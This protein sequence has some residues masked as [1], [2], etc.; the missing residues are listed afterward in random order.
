[1]ARIYLVLFPLFTSAF[2]RGQSVFENWF[3]PASDKKIEAFIMTQ[4]WATYTFGEEVYNT[5]T[6]VYELTEDRPNLHFRR[7]RL[8]FR[9]QVYPRLKFTLAGAYDLIGRDVLAGTNGG[10]NNGSLPKF[11]IWDAFFQW[12]MKEDSEAFNLIGGY[13]RP[14]FSRESITSAWSVNSMEKAMSQTYIR[15]HLT[16][17]GP[18]R[19]AG[20]NL[21]GLLKKEGSE[22]SLNYNIGVFNPLSPVLSGNSTGAE[23]APLIVGRTVVYFGDPEMKSY[24]IGYDINYYNERK[25]LALGFAGAWQGKTEIFDGNYAGEIDL[26]FNWSALN[27]DGEWNWMWRDD[28]SESKNFTYLSQTGHLRLGYNFI[29][30]KQYFLEPAFMIMAFKGGMSKEEQQNAKEIKTSAGQEQ[31]Y[32]FGLNWYMDKK[33]LKLSLHYTWRQGDPGQIGEGATVNSYFNQS[34]VGA[35]RRGNWLGLGMSAIF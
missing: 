28:A 18:G 19:A 32:D 30:G 14:Q 3:K 29:L 15:R 17:L 16:G 5:N 13:F 27:L 25:G 8:G 35:I 10:V 7:A 22:I 33:K 21:G 11:G 24:K 26:L 31:T 1:M 6:K 4:L 2:V 9:A 20:L 23:F 12:R 34:G